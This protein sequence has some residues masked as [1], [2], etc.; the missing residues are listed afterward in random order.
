M[1]KVSKSAT[2][3]LAA[4]LLEK[5]KQRLSLQ[6]EVDL[7]DQQEKDLQGQMIQLMASQGLTSVIEGGV[8]I[9]LRTTQEPVV[10]SWPD[11]LDY[12]RATNSLDLLQKRLTPSAVKARWEDKVEI[13]GVEQATRTTLKFNL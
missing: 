1:S 13:A 7:L 5:R 6:R 11:L 12:I 3:Q 8:D 9:E 4:T 2:S 10:Y